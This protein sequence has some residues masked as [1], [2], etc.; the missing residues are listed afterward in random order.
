MQSETCKNC[1]HWDRKDTQQV[2]GYND[3]VTCFACL[4]AGNVDRD[5]GGYESVKR[6]K[7]AVDYPVCSF[8]TDP[9]F[10]CNQFEMQ[11]IPQKDSDAK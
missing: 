10:G 9:E 8:V 11:D 6:T 7:F 4:R 2:R 3:A 1:R 5:E